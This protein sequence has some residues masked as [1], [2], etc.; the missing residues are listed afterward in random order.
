MWLP[1]CLCEGQSVSVIVLYLEKHIT[2]NMTYTTQ[3]VKE[4]FADLQK[5][6]PSPF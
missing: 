3:I 1:L 2:G 4:N 6:F 5:I